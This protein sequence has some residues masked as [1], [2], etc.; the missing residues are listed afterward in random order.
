MWDLTIVELFQ[1]LKPLLKD[2]SPSRSN[3]VNRK[4]IL[5]ETRRDL[6]MNGTAFTDICF[7]SIVATRTLWGNPEI[8]S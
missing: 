8:P 7:R 6:H 3:G 4:K 5:G 2:S 1:E